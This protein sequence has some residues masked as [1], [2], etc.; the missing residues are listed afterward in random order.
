[1]TS[2][3][4]ML[5]PDNLREE[6]HFAAGTGDLPNACGR[7][8]SEKSRRVAESEFGLPFDPSPI[9]LRRDDEFQLLV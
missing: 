2:V 3:N 7:S 9:S 5:I 4:D 8:V 6:F 1:M